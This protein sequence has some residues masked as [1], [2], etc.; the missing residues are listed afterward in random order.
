MT[1]EEAFIN[2]THP[3]LTVRASIFGSREAQNL[4]CSRYFGDFGHEGI[5]ERTGSSNS[6]LLDSKQPLTPQRR[7]Q[8]DH[9]SDAQCHKRLAPFR[10]SHLPDSRPRSLVQSATVYRTDAGQYRHRLTTKVTAEVS[11]NEATVNDTSR[12]IIGYF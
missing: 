11:Q 1:T 8:H 7:S 3:L 10:Y 9:V 2:K 4:R 12:T 5:P 6:V